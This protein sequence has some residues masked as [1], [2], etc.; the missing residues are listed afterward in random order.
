M[1]RVTLKSAR[2]A[3]KTV[4]NMTNM[5]RRAMGLQFPSFLGN[6]NS[7]SLAEQHTQAGPLPG[8]LPSIGIRT[9]SI[10]DSEL[11]GLL[12]I[13]PGALDKVWPH[14]LKYLIVA[15]EFDL[16]SARLNLCVTQNNSVNFRCRRKWTQFCGGTLIHPKW[17]VTAAHC[18]NRDIIRHPKFLKVIAG[19]VRVH[20]NYCQDFDLFIT[21]ENLR[22][23]EFFLLP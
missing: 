21:H 2:S 8:S 14:I 22:K 10:W 23:W 12:V 20:F 7:E 18:I 9:K 5:T 4:P 3:T 15:I 1:N 17:V 16:L 19:K 6:L 11:Y 13:Q